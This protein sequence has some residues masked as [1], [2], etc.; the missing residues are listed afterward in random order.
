MRKTWQTKQLGELCEVFADG[1]WIESKDQSHDG[2]RLIQT[3]NVGEGVFKDRAD[4]ARYITEATF[5]RLRCTEVFEGDSLISRLPDPVGRSCIVP[6]TGERMITGVDCTIVRFRSEL[7]LPA[8]FNCYSQSDDYL[9]TVA[10]ECTGTTRNRISRSNLALTPIPVPPLAEQKRI[11]S[12]LDGALAGLAGADDNARMNRENASAIFESYL[13]SIFARRGPEWK[14][15]PLGDLVDF[16]NGVNFTGASRGEHVKILGVKDF[17]TNYWA[18]LE[19]LAEVTTN[20][21]LT[22]SD[23]LRENDLLF[24]RSNGNMALIG[25]CMLVG[26]VPVRV[27]HSG[28]TIRARLTGDEVAPQY[29]CHFLKSAGTRQRMISGGIGTNIKSLNQTTLSNLDVP[30]PPRAEQERIVRSLERLSRDTERLERV[31]EDKVSALDA[32]KRSL[33]HHAFSGQL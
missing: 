15:K 9:T 1:D 26:R 13:E 2:I 17:Q 16:R 22:D 29:L 14:D 32:L 21:T 23:L 27:V 20:G 31:Y 3:G 11:V 25:R 30:I 18:P 24:V 6:G 5:K 28:F 12:R 19:N 8:F 10:N 4:K 33:L 7:L